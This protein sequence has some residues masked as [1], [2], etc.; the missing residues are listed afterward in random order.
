MKKLSPWI[1]L[2]GMALPLGFVEATAQDAGKKVD[3][4]G[5]PKVAK[6]EMSL[7]TYSVAGGSAEAVARLVQEVYAAS[8]TRI[9]ASS[10]DRIVVYADAETNRA[11]GR[12][13]ILAAPA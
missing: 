7:Q 9:T 3:L 10:K 1:L 13:N 4:S 12:Q 8:P 6:G 5:K 11:S 2:A